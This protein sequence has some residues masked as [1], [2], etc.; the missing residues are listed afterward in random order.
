MNFKGLEDWVEIFR[1]GKQTDSAGIE[2]DG[3]KLIESAVTNF[4]VARHEPP[5]VIGHPKN[6]APAFAW[7]ENLKSE[8]RNGIKV[9][10]AKFK[11]VVPE[12]EEMVRN[13]LF[14]K[15]SAAFYR[16]G[17]LRHVGFLGA[18]PPAVKGLQ[19]IGF[20]EEEGGI[21]FEFSEVNPWTWGAIASVFRK[22][23]E[24]FIEKEG[25]EKADE[26]IPEWNIED[27]KKEETKEI[28][29]GAEA[30]GIYTNSNKG[31]I[32]MN[33]KEKVKGML[34][35]LGVDVSKVPDEA[36]PD[37]PDGRQAQ[38]SFTE[39]DLKKIR[40]E[41]EAE[42]RKKAEAE[43]SKKMHKEAGER[44]M[45]E[46]AQF[47]EDG[48]KQGRL[49]PAWIK[50]GIKEFME[51]LDSEEALEFAEKKT[52]R[53]DWF[54]GF[55]SDLPK[56]VEFREIATRGEDFNTGSAGEKIDALVAKKMKENKALDYR[57]AFEEVQE[58]HP[59]LA[60]EYAAQF[61]Q[62]AA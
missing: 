28:E 53:F 3:D 39:T 47:C 14:K 26:I 2:H 32:E 5:A 8:T 30:S 16:D 52:S 11:Q 24:Y 33:F 43:F 1:G 45:R 42:G 27:V 44:R 21:V 55:L 22:L 60:A 51:S 46:I 23:R 25:M 58:E 59:E 57:S 17:S 7:V 31:G 38:D 13:G 29:A 18:A 48:M 4:D 20:R 62:D 36:L 6:D 19:E 49:I 40:E 56:V 61:Q 15:R 10:L 37:A 41:G 54:K 12:F 50:M 9:L 34:S 35:A